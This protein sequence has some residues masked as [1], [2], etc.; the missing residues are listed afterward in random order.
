ML[1]VCVC[2]ALPELVRVPVSDA[3]TVS[4]AVADALGVHDAL[5]D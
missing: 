2:E 4:L 5:G 3:V 1:W